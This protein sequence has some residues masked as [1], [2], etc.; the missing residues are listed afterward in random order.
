MTTD[1]KKRCPRCRKVKPI[2]DYSWR[3]KAKGLR[4]SYCKPCRVVMHRE[5][6]QGSPERQERERQRQREHYKKVRAD[7]EAYAARREYDRAMAKL[8]RKAAKTDPA[9]AE[10]LAAAHR[11][12]WEGVKA[13]PERHAA[14][15]E[16]RRIDQAL[17]RERE[18]GESKAFA[19]RDVSM[20]KSNRGK[21]GYGLQLD[22][23]PL[24]EWVQA[25]G[26]ANAVAR[27]DETLARGLRRIITGESKTASLH[28]VD[29]LCVVNDD[30]LLHDIYDPNKYPEAFAA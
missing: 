14:H 11:R 1:K 16:N 3:N 4:S 25:N 21:G 17:R 26:G 18:T 6:T 28:I 27:G 19:L 10:R 24:I 23:A 8:R 7:P 13:D 12:W 30:L 5:Y 20:S 22:P 2:E 29:S 9:I 15:L